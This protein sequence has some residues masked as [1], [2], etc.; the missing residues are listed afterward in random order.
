MVAYD[1]F[2]A[3]SPFCEDDVCR[4]KEWEE[5]G[6]DDQQV[7]KVVVGIDYGYSNGTIENQINSSKDEPDTEVV[8]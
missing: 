6:Y 4:C 3:H 8:K 2:C 5:K 7:V 1:K